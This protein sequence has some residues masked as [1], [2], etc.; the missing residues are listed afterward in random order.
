M[1]R[2][3]FIK[4]AAVAGC[5]ALVPVGLIDKF[6]NISTVKKIKS[7]ILI[8]SPNPWKTDQ[9]PIMITSQEQMD[10]LYGKGYDIALCFPKS[11]E[12]VTIYSI[13]K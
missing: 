4:S 11:V 1:N 5:A 9:T 6:C 10:K 3:Q 12:P 8:L 13:A 7:K 2:R